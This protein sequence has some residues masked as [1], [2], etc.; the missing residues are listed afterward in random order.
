M[1]DGVPPFW[2]PGFTRMAGT[3]EDGRQAVRDIKAEGYDFV[4]VYGALNVDT[5]LAIVDEAQKQKLRTLGHIPLKARDNIDAIFVPNYTMVAHAEE[6]AHLSHSMSDEE[7]AHFVELAKRNGTA[8]TASLTL[9][10][11]ILEQTRGGLA[12]LKSRPE[13]RYLHPG[14]APVWFEMNRYVTRNSPE[15]IA[16]LEKTVE[17][18]RKLVKA[19]VQ[20]GIPV[21]AGTDSLVPGVMPGFAL[22]DELEAMSA[23]G[24]TNEQVLQSATRM[25]MEWLGVAADRGTVEAGKRADL[26]LLDADPL[27]NVANTRKIAAV[28]AGDRYLTRSDLDGMLEKLTKRYA[29]M[30]RP[31]H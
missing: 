15:R 30:P 1:L 17:F 23:A 5:F 27:A 22:H 2:P 19:F 14:V 4:K 11:R 9:D 8:L 18:N 25:A 16:Q 21:F 26:L 12:T 28:I 7:I 20:A 13:L 24:M 3:P 10:D 29:T 31:R 6:F